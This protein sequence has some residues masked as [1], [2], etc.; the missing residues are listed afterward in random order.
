[1]LAAFLILVFLICAA[2]ITL[3][4]D[5]NIV[6]GVEATTMAIATLLLAVRCTPADT[7]S[8]LRLSRPLVLFGAVPALWMIIQMLPLGYVGLANPVFESAQSTLGQTVAGSIAIDTGSELL[9]LCQYMSA[10][11]ILLVAMAIAFDRSRADGL[12]FALL[13]AAIF[14]CLPT[15]ELMSWLRGASD[16]SVDIGTVGNV[17]AIGVLLAAAVAIRAFER[18]QSSR[19]Y[20]RSRIL[21]AL[22]TS[23]T[24]LMVCGSAIALHW[25]NNLAF[26]L[27]VALTVFLAVMAV[28]YFQIGLWGASAIAIAVL[29]ASIA[30]I[31]IQFGNRAFD[32]MLA[33]S[34]DPSLVALTKR[35]L[36]DATWTGSG[37]G[38]F[39][40]LSNIYR[41]S[42]D[43]PTVAIAPTAAAKIAIEL[44]RPMLWTILIMLLLV[45]AGLLRGALRRGR[46]AFYP[47]LGAGC[48]IAVLIF[49]FGNT[50]IL[51]PAASII[52]AAT[53]G[54]AL[55]QSSGRTAR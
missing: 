30:L 9:A 11:A 22:A 26:G 45:I 5:G 18:R 29:T 46:D 55:A 12:L 28:R 42:G 2:P 23:V 54:L 48:L 53:V 14:I 40:A 19:G 10:A 6:S 41:E 32:P 39:E 4:V 7:Q 34:D 43:A 8:L 25:T 38:S 1:V 24:S 49:A 21:F 50:G 37:A 33:Y 13:T 20:S 17:G 16:Q 31:W 35:V 27:A 36:S 52:A 51:A 3:F 47:A 15:A 44:G